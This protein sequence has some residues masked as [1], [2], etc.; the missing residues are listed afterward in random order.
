M[1]KSV[2]C[3]RQWANY[4]SKQMAVAALTIHSAPA[5]V[6]AVKHFPATSGTPSTLATPVLKANVF[7]VGGTYESENRNE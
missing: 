3:S 2:K 5:K 7:A 6:P 1:V 4:I